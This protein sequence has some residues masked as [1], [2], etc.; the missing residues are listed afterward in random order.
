MSLYHF[1]SGGEGIRQQEWS[2]VRTV[3]LQLRVP[4]ALKPHGWR[5]T[6]L[7]DEKTLA[8]IHT[9]R[10]KRMEFVGAGSA[11]GI[12]SRSSASGGPVLEFTSQLEQD[13]EQQTT[14]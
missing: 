10:E 4:R 11:P 7:A 2:A 5:S 13:I 12:P 3:W 1:N 6:C 8:M 14:V 9:I